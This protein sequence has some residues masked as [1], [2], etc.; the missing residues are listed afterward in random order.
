MKL[1]INCKHYKYVDQS[2]VWNTYKHH[3]LYFYNTDTK[4]DLVT[5]EKILGLPIFCH[6][7]RANEHETFCGTEAKFY[8][9]KD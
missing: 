4:F 8:D 3:C 9:P 5:G 2:Q 7:M 1:C 6:D